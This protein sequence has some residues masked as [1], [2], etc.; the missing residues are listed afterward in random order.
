MDKNISF[1]FSKKLN[2]ISKTS[3]NYNFDLPRY[4]VDFKERIFSTNHQIVI[5]PKYTQNA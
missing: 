4:E 1:S 5:S 2:L 3:K